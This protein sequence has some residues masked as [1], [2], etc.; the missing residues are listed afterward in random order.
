MSSEI[1]AG[2]RFEHRV[3][4][5]Q[6][7]NGQRGLHI[8]IEGDGSPWVHG[9]ATVARN[10]TPRNPLA[11]QLMATSPYTSVYV[12]RPCYF[13]LNQ[14]DGCDESFWTSARYGR[15]VV[16][17]MLAVITR[18]RGEQQPVVLIGY[19]G[20]GTLA[21]LL[22]DQLEGP[23]LLITIAGNLDIDRWT[24]HHGYL[25]LTDSLNPMTTVDLR[26]LPQAHL[27][28][29]RDHVVPASQIEAFALQQGG[30]V[31]QFETFDHR[32]CWKDNW[33]ALLEEL[34]DGVF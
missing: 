16:A 26:D 23:R 7:S 11:L 28:A 8:Y 20:G 24:E 14:S 4:H 9:G 31:K 12:G 32:C 18:L 2:A 21:A 3:F 25:P 19:S 29:L 27:S 22:A 10:P 17:S 6:G 33:P 1:I 5:H 15:E 30:S 34:L 13:D